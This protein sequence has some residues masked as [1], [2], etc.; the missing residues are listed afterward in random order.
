MNSLIIKDN[1]R[2]DKE[3]FLKIKGLT[4]QIKNKTLGELSKENLFIFPKAIE[5]SDDLE[6]GQMILQEFNN[7]IHS[8]NVMGFLGRG[9][10]RLVISSR[11]DLD[12][13]DYFLKYL[14]QR[15]FDFPNITSFEADSNRD[16]RIFNFLAFLFPVYL[17]SA[18]RKGIFKTYI[19]KK[20][21]DKNVKGAIDVH[22]HIIKNTPFVCN[23]AYNQ[24]EYSYDNY[25]TELVRHTAEY[26]KK[27]PYGKEILSRA[28]QQIKTIILATPSYEQ[29]D[30]GRVILYNKKNPLRHAYYS[31]YRALQSLCLFILE[32]QKHQIGAGSNKLYGVLFDGAWLWEEYIN[33]IIGDT[34][35]HPRNKAKTGRNYLFSGGTGKIYP[36]FISK[37]PEERIIADAKYKPINNISREDYFQL[38]AYMLRF[39]SQKG[40]YLYPEAEGNSPKALWLNRGSSFEGNVSRRE[41]FLVTKYGFQIPKGA[42]NYEEFSL[43]MR[44]EEKRCLNFVKIKS[45]DKA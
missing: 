21:N 30:R 23:I 3:E 10:E 40:Y 26:I 35:Y 18:M 41:D 19:N 22:R 6:E 42:K 32:H 7:K 27:K 33:Q 34:F 45:I 12:G 28:K 8:S 2:I 17:K 44:E 29:F 38:L 24:R 15:V 25:L 5:D 31:E 43:K 11:F 39:D 36:D 16:E 1:S 14:I 37:N 9:E 4:E 13:R 20:Y